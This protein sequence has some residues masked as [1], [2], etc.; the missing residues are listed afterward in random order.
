MMNIIIA[1][2]VHEN[3]KN[4]EMLEIYWSFLGTFWKL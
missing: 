3:N 2:H 1:D 4:E